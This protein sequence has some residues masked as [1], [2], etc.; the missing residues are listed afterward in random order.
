VNLTASQILIAHHLT[1]MILA[2]HVSSAII[3]EIAAVSAR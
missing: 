2:E 1:A 3:I